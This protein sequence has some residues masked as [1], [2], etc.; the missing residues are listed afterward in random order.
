MK[1]INTPFFVLL[2]LGVLSGCSGGGSLS[3]L[4]SE[5]PEVTDLS[6]GEDGFRLSSFGGTAV[7]IDGRAMDISER[8]EIV[9]TGHLETLQSGG[10][11]I[12][13]MLMDSDGDLVESFGDQGQVSLD[14]GLNNVAK[15]V[16]F[17]GKNVVI[18][19]QE[20]PYIVLT[21]VDENGNLDASFQGDGSFRE[22]RVDSLNYIHVISMKVDAQDRI[23]IGGYVTPGKSLLLRYLP[24]GEPDVSFGSDGIVV[25]EHDFGLKQGFVDLL[26]DGRVVLGAL[27]SDGTQEFSAAVLCFL[28]DGSLDTSFGDEGNGMQ[29]V[30]FNEGDY[31]LYIRGLGVDSLGRIVVVSSNNYQNL[32]SSRAV[33]FRLDSEGQQDLTFGDDGLQIIAG[34]ASLGLFKPVFDGDKI[35]IGGYIRENLFDTKPIIA[36]LLDSGAVDE[37][38][39]YKG[40]GVLEVGQFSEARDTAIYGGRYYVGGY[41]GDDQM[42]VGAARP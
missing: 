4:S 15:A 3:S 25:I 36:R 27:L 1:S 12:G 28:E 41:I 22:D 31:G 37:T 23:Y 35:V 5:I 32:A 20:G 39:G 38:Y 6:F 8:G 34:G 26:P 2:L 10:K 30:N 42:M 33:I 24:D 40:V 17:Q 11:N 13:V 7:L 21:R 29:S 16:G 14:L 18:A 19:S 9:I